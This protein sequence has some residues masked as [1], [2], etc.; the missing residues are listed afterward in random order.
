MPNGRHVNVE[1]AFSDWLPPDAAAEGQ[2]M[3]RE[4][5]V[6]ALGTTFVTNGPSRKARD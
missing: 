4:A 5:A 1:T 3:P 6:A 2:A